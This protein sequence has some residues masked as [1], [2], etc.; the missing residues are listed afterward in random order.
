MLLS[1]LTRLS[2]ACGALF[3][4]DEAWWFK[5]DCQRSPQEAA[6]TY[7][8]FLGSIHLSFEIQPLRYM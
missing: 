5:V 4:K 2:F 8:T 6:T 1:R 3:S 7:S